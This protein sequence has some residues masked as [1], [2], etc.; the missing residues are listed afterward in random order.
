MHQVQFDALRCISLFCSCSTLLSLSVPTAKPMTV[1]N[2]I[3]C[4]F[5]APLGDHRIHPSL[6]RLEGSSNDL[7]QSITDNELLMPTQLQTHT[8]GDRLR[9]VLRWFLLTSS[10]LSEREPFVWASHPSCIPRQ[11]H[12]NR[13]VSFGSLISF[14]SPFATSMRQILSYF[15]T[16]S[17]QTTTSCRRYGRAIEIGL[18]F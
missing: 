1:N 13:C 7:R 14:D 17:L 10:C 5:L 12:C 3:P 8:R 15:C 18:C 4:M 11:K 9:Y 2:L 6:Q 16:T